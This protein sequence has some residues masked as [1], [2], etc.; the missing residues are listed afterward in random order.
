MIP[1]VGSAFSIPLSTRILESKQ[2]VVHV[3][4][5]DGPKVHY[6]KKN[7][8]VHGYYMLY[9]YIDC[10][11]VVYGRVSKKAA[12]LQGITGGNRDL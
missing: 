9:L 5:S 10:E 1:M 3:L 4:I 2:A 12:G 11:R 7:R 8:Y 6:V